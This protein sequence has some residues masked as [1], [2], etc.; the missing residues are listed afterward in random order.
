[1][2]R[3]LCHGVLGVVAVALL[4]ASVS[5]LVTR[6]LQK[7]VDWEVQEE[8]VL[9]N[10][11]DTLKL[12][13]E[14]PPPVYMQFYI[15][16]VTNPLEILDGE[17]PRVTEIGP[18]TYRED[19]PKVNVHILENGTK[20]SFLNP[21]TFY[22]VP[23]MSAGDPK[24]DL[25]RTVNVPAVFAM[26]MAAATPLRLPMEFLLLL[27]KEE[28]FS[29]HTAH[30]WLWGYEDRFLRA[31]HKMR[32]VVDSTFGFFDKMNGTD[33]GEYIVLSGERNY[34]DFTRI[35]EW[36]GQ[37]R[38]DWW[39][40]PES[41]MINGTDGS[42]F[43]PLIDPEETVYIF[44]SDFCRSIPLAYEKYV[45]VKGIPAYRFV[46]PA[47][48]YANASVNKDNA[49]FCVPAGQCLGTG[50]LN[51]STCLQGAPI[52]ISPP[53]FYASAEEYIRFAMQMA[54]ATP[55]RL[56]MEFLL[57]LYKEEMFSIHT[58][59]EWLW[60]YEDR[61][62]RAMHKM[63]PVVDS[64]F[65][66]FDKMNGTDD[67][68]YI[69][70][71]GERNYKDFT[72]IV[73]WKGQKRLDWWTSPESNMING[74]DGSSFH[75]LI[76]P[77]ETVYIFASDFC[78]SIPLA[79]EKYVKVKGIPA[80]RFVPPASFYANASVNKE[81][82]GFCVPAG[83][84]LG[85]GILNVSTCLQGA[86]ILISPPHFYASAEEYIK[87]VNGM[88]PNKEDHQ[89]FL[90][91]NPTTGLL[92]RACKRLQ[93]NVFVQS[94]PDFFQ[95]GNIR[96]MIFP[97]LHLNESVLLDDDSA[98]KLRLALFESSL[99]T[100][101]PYIIMAVGVIF[102]IVFVVFACRPFWP[103]EEGSEDERAPLIRT[104]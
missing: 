12:W 7:A 90:D 98:A 49:G 3:R 58:A 13:E 21:R 70:L 18:Y 45:K 73:E 95:T 15:F 11:S 71:S 24:V 22:F 2:T 97:V 83:Q 57:L 36:K 102:G 20:V 64:T 59:H 27:Y 86:P 66:F 52:L 5:L 19:R 103:K 74:T 9:K 34:K 93:I 32:P 76:D 96:T 92:V 89:T 82:A 80:Y 39:T 79:Y 40:S 10:G 104:S 4:I 56:P 8:M 60:G 85:T 63:R 28:M 101:V 62:L 47:S 41:N 6:V 33:D 77:E 99:L 25:I 48:F 54:A 53:H 50:I 37:K 68:E 16:N 61:F 42:S 35:V 46:P 81:N 30:E 51:V 88:H 91:I 87:S 23:E 100:S 72:R 67:G 94:L 14:P 55:L 69:V 84:C 26:Q 29:I 44:A 1:M 75:P 65:G 17:I 31:M 38:L 43:H 78:R